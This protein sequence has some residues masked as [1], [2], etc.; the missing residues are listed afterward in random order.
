MALW[1]EHLKGAL[2]VTSSLNYDGSQPQYAHL[3]AS[4]LAHINLLSMLQ[5]FE[6]EEAV[7]VATDS[8]YVRKYAL[9]KAFVAPKRCDCGE[10]GC[11]LCLLEEDYDA[12]VEVAPGQWRDKG[13]HLYMPMKHAAYLAKPDYI[14]TKKDLTP[15]TMPHHDDPLSRHRLSYL[16]SGG[17]SG[18]TTRAI[19]LFRTRNPLVFTPTHS[20]AKEMRARG[21]QAQT[22][23]SFF[24]WSGQTDWTPKRMGQTPPPPLWSYGTRSSK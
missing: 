13:E 8:I 19:E 15:S 10:V 24:R 7:R 21:A 23:N 5:R 20:L 6:S 9:H 18:K 3:R 12:P 16:N 17:G 11:V 22:Y 2:W 4:M 1:S 14:A